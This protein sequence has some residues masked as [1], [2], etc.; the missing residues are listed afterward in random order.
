MT[1]LRAPR[2]HTVAALATFTALTLAG[3]AGSS[4]EATPPDEPATVTVWHTYSDA[5]AAAYQ[6]I[7]ESFNDSQDAV[8]VTALPQPYSD[9]D[10]KVMQAVRNGNG[11]DIIV[12]SP[13]SATAYIE[14][15]LVAD[16]APLVADPDTGVPDFATDIVPGRQA[17][18][19]Q[20]EDGSQYLY[21]IHSAG[22]V[23]FYNQTLF[24]ELGLEAPQTWTE[25]ETTS[26]TITDA[27]GRPAFGF[28]DL[29]YGIIAIA[30]QQGQDI[31]NDDATIATFDSP[32]YVEAI[33]WVQGLV[34]DGVFRLVGGDQFFSNPFGAEAVAA[35]LGSSAGYPFV[36]MA[37]DGK[38]EVGVVPMPQEGPVEYAPEWGGDYLVFA[39]DPAQE[40]AAFSFV[41]YF[42]SPQ[43][44]STWDMA[45]GAVPAS[46]AAREEPAFV[47]FMAENAAMKALATQLPYT[48]A[49]NAA[50]GVDA[51]QG[52]LAIA[53]E[54][55]MTGQTDT[56]A[57]LSKA[58][59]TATAS[60]G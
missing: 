31:V 53:I 33:D 45:L 60:L 51:A 36:D 37:V 25:L 41:K 46:A 14:A 10:S 40:S 19:T 27:T 44:L 5:H 59:K 50:P 17:S 32:E 42:T 23:L 9:F 30:N 12:S 1:R 52:E 28:D 57:A 22:P 43:P 15:R 2:S 56:L 8:Q 21:P 34:D 6:S 13:Q 55:A 35:Y 20:W 7:V 16:L 58:A 26:R 39:S 54:A 29:T 48:V 18:V 3:C 47:E 4:V 24:D 38:F 11:P 49:S